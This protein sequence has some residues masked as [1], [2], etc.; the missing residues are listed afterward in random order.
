VSGKTIKDLPESTTTSAS[1]VA[2]I[3]AVGKGKVNTE[4]HQFCMYFNTSSLERSFLQGNRKA[5][6]L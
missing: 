1:I 6:N 5:S 2:Q 4:F 3:S